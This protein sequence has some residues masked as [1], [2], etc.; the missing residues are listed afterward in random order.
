MCKCLKASKWWNA[1]QCQIYSATYILGAH[2]TT[3]VW[4][5]VLIHHNKTLSSYNLW[6][7]FPS[8]PQGSW[9]LFTILNKVVLWLI[10]I[11]VVFSVCTMYSMHLIL[12]SVNMILAVEWYKLSSFI[13]EKDG[14]ETWFFHQQGD[15]NIL[16]WF[17][18]A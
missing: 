4:K 6:T 12:S 1:V 5:G 10:Y 14:K 15:A 17:Q 18:G 13:A 2:I 11:C 8:D 16:H 7:I 9:L 3:Q